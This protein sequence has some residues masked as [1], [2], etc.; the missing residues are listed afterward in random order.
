MPPGDPASGL[1]GPVFSTDELIEATS[2]RAWVASML[3]FEA[4]LATAEAEVGLV[5]T[6]AAAAIVRGCHDI[7]IDPSALGRAGRLGASPAIPLV[8]ELRRQLPPDVARWVHFGATSQD[9]LDTALMLVLRRVIDLVLGD[10][11]RLSAAA[12]AL[13]EQ[14]R[15]T[16]MAART[17][18]QHASPTTFGRKAAG[19]LVAVIEVGDALREAR[20]HRLAVQLGGP[21]GTLAALGQHGL[22]VMDALA[23]E[24]GLEVPVLPWHTDRTRVVEISCALALSAGVVGKV[25]LDVA[26]L[27]QTEVSEVFEPSTAGRGGSSSLPHKRNPAMAAE[28]LAACRRAEALAGVVLSG[29]PQEHERAVGAWQAEWQTV[30]EL[31]GAAGGAV[32]FAADM[33]AGLEVDTAR[34]AKN[35]DLTRGLV[36]A[37]RVTAELTPLLGFDEARRVVEQACQRAILSGVCLREAL[38]LEPV[39]AEVLSR[40][41]PDLFDP[42]GWLGSSEVFV[43]RALELYHKAYDHG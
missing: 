8:A 17:L 1:F 23:S 34:M 30:S 15:S 13:A 40:L 31:A 29:M 33:V 21:G 27:M 6:S 42:A 3:E 18:L 39:S 20:R 43:N 11:A 14:H 4:A 28:I 24:L 12:A 35:L 10:V 22:Q 41:P 26:L 32:S 25:A 9:V 36:L 19:W 2:D 7:D 16:L 37:E 38:S 5:P